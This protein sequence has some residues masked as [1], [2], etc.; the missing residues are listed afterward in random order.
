MHDYG[1]LCQAITELAVEQE[2]PIAVTEFRTLNRCLDNAIADAVTR[3]GE[4]HEESIKD[5][6]AQDANERLGILAHELRGKLNVAFLAVEAIKRGTANMETGMVTNSRSGPAPALREAAGERAL[7]V[8]QVVLSGGSAGNYLS[9]NLAWG[10]A[11]T[12]A[13][14]VAGGVSGAHL[15]P[16]VTVALA[17][18]RKFAWHKV[19]PYS[20]AQTVGAFTASAVVFAS[21]NTRT[22]KTGRPFGGL[23]GCYLA[24]LCSFFCR[25]LVA[26]GKCRR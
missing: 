9:I 23:P 22:Q 12:M 26:G 4:E 18:H 11:V 10:I 20:I 5:S 1:D 3:F 14:Y 17:V 7:R 6:A 15:N 24:C 25:Y 13:V 8:A 19:L 21:I 2:A 16:A